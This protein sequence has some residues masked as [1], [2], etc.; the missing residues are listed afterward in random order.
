MR[1]V[2]KSL[3]AIGHGI[4]RAEDGSKVV[5]LFADVMTRRELVLGERVTFSI[6]RV[7]DN[8]F[9]ENICREADNSGGREP[10]SDPKPDAN[11]CDEPN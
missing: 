9:A 5:F 1:G 4:I 10:R 3:D 6:R 2:V 7:H 8:I 11:S